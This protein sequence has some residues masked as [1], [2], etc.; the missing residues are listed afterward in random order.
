V[1]D[2]VQVLD[3]TELAGAGI[4][5]ETKRWVRGENFTRS[6]VAFAKLLK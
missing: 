1:Q 3:C 2:K 6:Y 5:E 4:K